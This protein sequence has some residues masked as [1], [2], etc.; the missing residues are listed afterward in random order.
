MY[1]VCLESEVKMKGLIERAADGIL[2]VF[3]PKITA[4]ACGACAGH[5][6]EVECYCS[7][8]SKYSRWCTFNCYCDLTECTAC[9]Y[10]TYDPGC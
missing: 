3:A 6:V 9:I 4:A 7:D 10:Y 5:R 1:E 2:G 8:N